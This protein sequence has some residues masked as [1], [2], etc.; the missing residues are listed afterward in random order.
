MVKA[1]DIGTMMLGLAVV[2]VSAGCDDNP[3]SE[4]RSDTVRF[5]SS[6]SFV[7]VDAADTVAIEALPVNNFA[8]PTGAV[9]TATAC[10][11]GVTVEEDRDRVNFESPGGFIIIGQQLGPSCIEVSAGGVV[12]TIDV[13]VVPASMEAE[14]GTISSGST[15]TVNV[16][17]FDAAGDAITGFDTSDLNFSLSEVTVGDIDESGTITGKTPGSSTVVVSINPELHAANRSAE[18]ELLVEPG[19]FGGTVSTAT[20]EQFDT[21]QITA[22]A[23]RPFDDDT[24]I[25]VNGRLLTDRLILSLDATQAEFIIP[26][27][28]EEEAQIVVVNVGEDQLGLAPDIEITNAGAPDPF[29]PN[30]LPEDAVAI[31]LPFHG[32]M[33]MTDEDDVDDWFI[34]ELTEET[35][36]DIT[37]DWN[38][39]DGDLDMVLYDDQVSSVGT[40]FSASRPEVCSFTL[41]AGTYFLRANVFSLGEENPRF[42]TILTV[43]VE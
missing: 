36:L 9:P 17:F 8:E 24:D 14:V 26:A 33:A 25:M 5:R 4:G 43:D 3:L 11:A 18:A 15:G 20:A 2:L 22:S 34:F 41:D 6:H 16:T 28:P 19:P 31:D 37:L 29:E 13:R 7:V 42:T 32:V 1:R 35:T 23:E 21:V 30:D 40:C 27:V 10:N 38:A 39:S 12:D